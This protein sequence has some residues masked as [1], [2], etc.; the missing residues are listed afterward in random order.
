MQILIFVY[1]MLQISVLS[2]L[3]NAERGKG[4]ERGEN[5]DEFSQNDADARSLASVA[6]SCLY[7]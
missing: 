2:A 5:E 6:A 7:P 4:R 3:F 1:A